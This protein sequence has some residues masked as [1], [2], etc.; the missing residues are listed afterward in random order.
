MEDHFLKPV[1]LGDQVLDVLDRDV[2]LPEPRTHFCHE[3]LERPPALDASAHG[4]IQLGLP[5]ERFD[6]CIK[7]PTI[8]PS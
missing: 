6:K 5:G 2:A 8:K 7:L 4:V 1:S 3:S